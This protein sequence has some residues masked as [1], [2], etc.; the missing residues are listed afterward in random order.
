MNAT[1]DTLF[2]LIRAQRRISSARA[3][4]RTWRK[5]SGRTAATLLAEAVN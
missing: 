1:R 3:R 4:V 2:A 5:V